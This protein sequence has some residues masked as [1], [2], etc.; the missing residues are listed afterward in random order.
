M[1]VDIVNS[2]R[3]L[4][5]QIPHLIEISGYRQDYLSQKMNLKPATFS[6]KKLKG[7]WSP[8][9]VEQLLRI[10]SN[11]E[12]EDFMMLQLMEEI[13]DEETINY[14]TFKSQVL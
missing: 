4:L 13:V 14:D 5:E 12:V 1:V 3:K 6:A 7:N 8:D 2:Y 10:I 11:E 9:E